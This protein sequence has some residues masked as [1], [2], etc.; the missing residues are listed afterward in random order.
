M[1]ATS[2]LSISC[3][4]NWLNLFPALTPLGTHQI[5]DRVSTI[6]H[7]RFTL[8]AQ[9][10]SLLGGFVR[11]ASVLLVVLSQREK[12]IRIRWSLL[13][14]VVSMVLFWYSSESSFR[15]DERFASSKYQPQ[16]DTRTY[17][18]PK[19]HT[20]NTRIYLRR[21]NLSNHVP[22]ARTDHETSISTNPSNPSTV[23]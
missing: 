13:W 17:T 2:D 9:S 19:C 23:R 5:A 21:L 10:N 15:L 16:Q 3:F 6:L 8:R 14:S 22:V 1:H 11:T 4:H 7:D 20:D 12:K 18:Q